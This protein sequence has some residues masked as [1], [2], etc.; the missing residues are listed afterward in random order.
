MWHESS[1]STRVRA[2][3]NQH[4]GE[5]TGEMIIVKIENEISKA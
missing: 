1:I 5:K 3:E 4:H 2:D